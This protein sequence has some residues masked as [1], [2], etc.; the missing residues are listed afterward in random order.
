M[1]Y[2]DTGVLLKL[3]LPE[4]NSVRAVELVREE[5]EVPLL[6]ALHRLEIQ[7]ALGQKA[8]RREITEAERVKVR[9]DF[10][11]DI[12][13]GVFG[14]AIVDWPGVFARAE[15]LAAMHTPTTH[16][17]SLDTLHVALALQ[18][19][20]AEFCTFDVRQATMARAAGLQVVL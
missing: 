18:M 12:L 16:C 20:A 9:E 17:R 11:R 8:G 10:E 2:F 13:D 3:Y 7:S 6:S 15:E 19:G 4:P 14:A 1:R 5:G